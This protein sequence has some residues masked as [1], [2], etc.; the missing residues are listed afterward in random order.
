[1]AHGQISM[2][3]P[4]FHLHWA[5]AGASKFPDRDSGDGHMIVQCS[6]KVLFAVV[7]GSGS[8]PN[9]AI[10]ADICLSALQSSAH[11]RLETDFQ[12]CHDGLQGKR[13]AAMGLVHIDTDTGIMTWASVGDVYGVRF[14]GDANKRAQAA[15]I[16]RRPGTLGVRYDGILP[17]LLTLALGDVVVWSTDGITQEFGHH[18]GLCSS[19]EELADLILIGHGKPADDSLVLVIDVRAA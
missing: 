1:M 6:D 16:L 15:V 5:V 13:G 3:P 2:G 18:V 7:D 17:Q 8:G 4:G 10:A 12:A 9:A 11:D 14:R 19:A